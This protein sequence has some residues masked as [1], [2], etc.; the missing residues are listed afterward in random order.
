MSDCFIAPRPV[1]SV[2]LSAGTCALATPPY[3]HPD[4]TTIIW[5][6][7]RCLTALPEK[8]P[9]PA[10]YWR[11]AGLSQY[12]FEKNIDHGMTFPMTMPRATLSGG[13]VTYPSLTID[14]ARLARFLADRGADVIP[15]AVRVVDSGPVSFATGVL[16]TQQRAHTIDS[17]YRARTAHDA[18]GTDYTTF[19]PVD[20][21]TT[22]IDGNLEASHRSLRAH[23]QGDDQ[24]RYHAFVESAA[25]MD[26]MIAAGAPGAWV[27][28]PRDISSVAEGLRDILGQGDMTPVQ[29]LPPMEWIDRFTRLYERQ[30]QYRDMAARAG[31][32]DQA[33][34]ARVNMLAQDVARAIMDT[35]AGQALAQTELSDYA[36][37]Y[38]KT[39]APAPQ[40]M[41]AP[42]PAIA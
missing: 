25:L 16:G 4:L 27:K 20:E 41:Y 14:D 9:M 28:N 26:Q 10:L 32:P 5:A 40:M 33:A 22:Y 6:D 31:V 39:F 2:G 13:V 35:A 7:A 36:H 29:A 12:R 1:F 15:V 24:A 3:A 19:M 17:L 34:C 21:L 11:G 42:M 8:A 37:R 38:L 23:W 30:F 18:A